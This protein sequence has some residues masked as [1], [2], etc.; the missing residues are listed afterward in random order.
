MEPQTAEQLSPN[1]K[2]SMLAVQIGL[3]ANVLLALLKGVGGVLTGSPALLADGINSTSDVAYG[4]V[5]AIFMRLSC[6]PADDDHPYGHEQLE[7]VAAVVI[8]AFIITTAI[9]IFWS[10]INS[11]YEITS[12]SGELTDTGVSALWIAL[13]AAALKVILSLW[14]YAV[15]RQVQSV[16][17]LA[18]AKDHRNDIF[19]SG[20]AALGIFF[21]QNGLPWV[22]PL[23]GA[24]VALVILKTGFEIL[25]SASNDLMDTLPDNQ[26]NQNIHAI[27][28]GCEA[29]RSV[30]SVYAHRFGPYLV[31]NLVISIDGNLSFS[32]A[33]RI[34]DMLEDRLEQEIPLLRKVHAHY[35]P[36]L[37]QSG[38]SQEQ[39]KVQAAQVT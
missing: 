39:K 38:E 33:H 7:S 24:I 27:L 3:A 18:L 4:V 22:D 26:L 2:K 17:V 13:F 21:G 36:A 32:E 15:H 23:A 5:V 9:A 34:V 1:H 30:D 25:L 37:S 6:K 12:S 10:A 11:I 35:H 20:A 29:V 8:G 14:T 16:A 19:A 31:V 28:L